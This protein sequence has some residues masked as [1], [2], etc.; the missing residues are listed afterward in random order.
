MKKVILCMSLC[1][2]L[3]FSGTIES[4][5]AEEPIWILTGHSSNQTSTFTVAASGLPQETSCFELSFLFPA[6]KTI[7]NVTPLFKNVDGSTPDCHVI[8]T[9]E[10]G[11]LRTKIYCV[12]RIGNV[13][14]DKVIFQFEIPGKLQ[15]SDVS[16]E[17]YTL[18]NQEL[19]VSAQK[20]G[21]LEFKLEYQSS[22]GSSSWGGSGSQIP[23]PQ[24]PVKV[25]EEEKDGATIQTVT[26]TNSTNGTVLEI[27][28]TTSKETKE[29]EVKA[30][31]YLAQGKVE[32]LPEAEGVSIKIELPEPDFPKEVKDLL[33]KAEI[34][35]PISLE[36]VLPQKQLVEQLKKD[37]VKEILINVP[38]DEL[39]K[40]TDWE[41][42]D[43][44]LP[45]EVLK[46]AKEEKKSVTVTMKEYSWM[47]TKEALANVEKITEDA[48]LLL[49][50]LPV[51]EKEDVLNILKKDKKYVSGGVTAV[52][53]ERR[54]LPVQAELTISLPKGTGFSSGKRVYL[55]QFNPDTEKLETLV[56]SFNYFVD[57]NGSVTLHVIS[58]ETYVM[59]PKA[60]AN[61]I[62]TALI[63]QITVPKNLTLVLKEEE[64]V[65]KT[66]EVSMPPHLEKVTDFDQKMKGSAYGGVKV[67]FK[68]S[69]KKVALVGKNGL[70]T[71][72]G[73]GTAKI[74]T[75]VTLYSG[76]KK[77]FTTVVTVKG[78]D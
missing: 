61:S 71:A 23:V 2:L 30:Y 70:V 21:D 41:L 62:I 6:G 73:T 42:I 50:I 28:L 11:K 10:N 55:Y 49:N 32:K 40:G 29:T 47:F 53:R 76:K 34:T 74:T 33:K 69:N 52:S 1:F 13:Y 72:V 3:F 8:Q 51:S 7:T 19:K 66:L 16:L 18:L 37:T 9:E 25:T 24:E 4:Y 45:T 78:E 38:I 57:E 63:S 20:S 59:L 5:A 54:A 46:V 14:S 15:K 75:T 56:R 60:A 68:S 48:S 12:N 35:E 17:S 43:L 67:Q 22:G 58:T 65:R 39:K 64:T 27:V 26:Y 31:Y 77:T 44:L 36:F